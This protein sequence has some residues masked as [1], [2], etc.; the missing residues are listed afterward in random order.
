MVSCCVP[1]PIEVG[2]KWLIRTNRLCSFTT[3]TS[4][5]HTVYVVHGFIGNTLRRRKRKKIKSMQH[6]KDGIRLRIYISLPLFKVS[7]MAHQAEMMT[8]H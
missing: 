3:F 7:V 8:F 6:F 2:T 4:Y 5:M 1:P